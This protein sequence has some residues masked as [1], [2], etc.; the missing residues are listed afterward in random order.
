M[1]NKFSHGTKMQTAPAVC[2]TPPVPLPVWP[3]PYPEKMYCILTY[4]SRSNPPFSY[5]HR[6]LSCIEE[7]PGRKYLFYDYITFDGYYWDGWAGLTFKPDNFPIIC[8]IYIFIDRGPP[9]W[10]DEA[11]WE[12]VRPRLIKPFRSDLHTKSWG[13]ILGIRHH[14]KVIFYDAILGYYPDFIIS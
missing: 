1:S 14:A 2:R 8:T 10:D 6:H 5:V 9:E 13:P 12:D 11:L 4:E 3:S 7:I